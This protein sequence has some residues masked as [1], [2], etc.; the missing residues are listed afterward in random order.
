MLENLFGSGET[1]HRD[2]DSLNRVTKYVDCNGHEV[3]YG[4]DERGNMVTLTYPGGEIV[5]YTYHDDGSVKTMESSSGGTFIYGYDN[6]GRL[7]KITRADGSTE[8]RKYDAAGQLIS[9][10]DKD[11]NGNILQQST[12]EYDVFGEMTT[13]STSNAQNPGVLATVT[14]TY[15]DANRLKTYNGETVRYDEKGN[16]TYGPVDGK[17]QELTYDCRNRLVE[18]GGITYT[19]DAENTRIATTED[20]LTTEYVTDTGGSL[21]RMITAYEA[22]NTRTLYYYGAEG[23][24]AQYNT[25]TGKYYA[26]HYDNIGSTTLITDRSG[27]AVE[28][29]SSISSPTAASSGT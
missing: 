24:A 29:F 12:Y 18:A 21:S 9:Q 23:L 13:K 25:G 4:Y 7:C 20:G 19:Y 3:K 8:E 14:M 17:M 16:M 22:D 1:I 28:R 11:K 2:F 6:Y 5:T 26:Y 15:D 10:T 27:Q